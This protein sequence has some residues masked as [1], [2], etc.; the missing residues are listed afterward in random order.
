[1]FEVRIHCIDYC[2]AAPTEV[3]TAAS[4]APLHR[5]FRNKNKG[6][7]RDQERESD[8]ETN[9]D[10]TRNYG[11]RVPI[12]RVFGATPAGKTACAHIHGAFPYLFVPFDGYFQPADADKVMDQLRRGL[13]QALGRITVLAVTLARGV[14]FYGFHV[15]LRLFCKIYLLDPA[16]MSR[17]AEMLRLGRIGGLPA[18]QPHEAHVPF[19]LQFMTDYNLYGCDVLRASTA[20]ARRPRTGTDAVGGD[21]L[22]IDIAAHHI[23]NRDAAPERRIHENMPEPPT[24]PDERLVYSMASLWREMAGRYGRADRKTSA[25]MRQS[26]EANTQQAFA[27]LAASASDPRRTPSAWPQEAAYRRQLDDI[28]AAERRRSKAAASDTILEHP[29]GDWVPTT[30]QSVED[31]YPTPDRTENKKRKRRPSEELLCGKTD[32][33]TGGVGFSPSPD[34]EMKLRALLHEQESGGSGRVAVVDRSSGAP[35]RSVLP[36]RKK[37]ENKPAAEQTQRPLTQMF[38]VTKSSFPRD[39]SK[40]TPVVPST[41][42]K[43]NDVVI[44][45]TPDYDLPRLSTPSRREPTWSPEATHNPNQPFYSVGDGV[46]AFARRPPSADDVTATLHRHGSEELHQDAF[47][48][49]EKDI[50]QNKYDN[51]GAG[52]RLPVRLPAFAPSPGSKDTSASLLS[53]CNARCWELAALPPS[54]GAVETWLADED[55]QVAKRERTAAEETAAARQR[56]TTAQLPRSERKTLRPLPK[57]RSRGG[58]MRVLVLE[59]HANSR[60]TFLPNPERDPVQCVFWRVSET[61]RATDRDAESGVITVQRLLRYEKRVEV[62]TDERD[63]LKR[64]VELAR[65]LDPDILAGYETTASSWGYL[66]ERAALY[67]ETEDGLWQALGRIQQPRESAMFERG[68]QSHMV[69]GRHVLGIA[70]AVRTDADLRQ[71]TIASAAWKLLRLRVPTYGPR[72]L[73]GWATSGRA[74]DLTRL[75]RFGCHR[76]AVG[77]ALLQVTEFVARTSE[78]A[79]VLGVDFA[80][81]LGRG[82]QYKVESVMLRVAK[83]ECFVLPSPSREQVGHQKAAEVAPLVLEPRSGFYSSPVIVLDFA[84][85]YP[86]LMI[87]YNLCYSTFLGSLDPLYDERPRQKRDVKPHETDLNSSGSAENEPAEG[88]VTTTV[89]D[90]DNIKAS[91][92]IKMGFTTYER[93]DGLLESANRLGVVV[94]PTGMLYAGASTRQSLLARMLAELLRTRVMVRAAMGENGDGA[95]ASEKQRLH[96]RQLALKLLANVTYGYTSASFSGR[97]PCVEVADSIVQAGRQTLDRAMALIHADARWQ[98]AEVVYGDTD[99]LFVHLPGRTRAQAFSIGAAMAAAVTAVNPAPVRLKFEK[100]YHPCVLLAKKRYVGYRFDSPRQLAPIWDAK[101]IETVRRDGTPAASA[102][103]EASL[104]LLFDTADLSLVRRLVQQRCADVLGGRVSP[105]DLCFARQVRSPASYRAPPPGAVVVAR[106]T[107]RDPRAA[108]LPDGDRVPFVIVAGPPGT[109][110]QDRCVAPAELVRS[111]HL[112]LDAD[113]Y[114][115]H[116]LL[117]PL[118]RVLRLVGVDVAQ[119]YADMARPPRT[120]TSWWVGDDDEDG[121]VGSD[122]GPDGQQTLDIWLRQWRC[123]LE[124]PRPNIAPS[125]T[126]VVVVPVWAPRILCVAQSPEPKAR[127]QHDHVVVPSGAL[128]ILRR[129][130]GDTSVAAASTGLSDVFPL[131]ELPQMPNDLSLGDVSKDETSIVVDTEPIETDDEEPVGEG[132]FSVQFEAACEEARRSAVGDF[133]DS[134]SDGFFIVAEERGHVLGQGPFSG[135]GLSEGPST[136]QGSSPDQRPFA[137]EEP[138]PPGTPRSSEDIGASGNLFGEQYGGPMGVETDE[139]SNMPM[140]MAMAMPTSMPT[141]MPTAAENYEE[142]KESENGENDAVAVS[143]MEEDEDEDDGS[144]EYFSQFKPRPDEDDGAYIDSTSTGRYDLGRTDADE[145]SLF[146]ALTPPSTPIDM[147]SLLSAVNVLPLQTSPL[148]ALQEKVAAFFRQGPDF[149]SFAFIKLQESLAEHRYVLQGPFIKVELARHSSELFSTLHNLGGLD[150]G[151]LSGYDH[152]GNGTFGGAG[153]FGGYD[154]YGAYDG[155]SALA[156]LNTPRHRHSSLIRRFGPLGRPDLHKAKP[157]H[158]SSN[159]SLQGDLWRSDRMASSLVML[160]AASHSDTCVHGTLGKHSRLLG[161]AP[162]FRVTQNTRSASLRTAMFRAKLLAQ[163]A[164]RT[165]VMAVSLVD[166]RYVEM[167]CF[168]GDASW[169]DDRYLSFGHIVT[170]GVG[171]E[172]VIIWQAWGPRGYRLDDYIRAGHARLRSWEEAE[173]FAKDF[174][175]LASSSGIWNARRNHLYQQLFYIDINQMCKPSCLNRLITPHYEPWVRIHTLHNVLYEN[176]NKFRFV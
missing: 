112:R 101:G 156:S 155:L 93:P 16:A 53:A 107:A 28:I 116:S 15:G 103:M 30:R 110:L 35:K 24:N 98:P 129:H 136:S 92:S 142:D 171:P 134:D 62:A 152:S 135:E 151:V 128:A 18:L 147:I 157:V 131:Q 8:R 67:T 78:Q 22:Q 71:Y 49:D 79:R 137:D 138:S 80:S 91:T 52:R 60:G 123:E 10:S 176:M 13:D 66:A 1:M 97:M 87:A 170:I 85:L 94:A 146:C 21:L 100:V 104:R 95:D 81:V 105:A 5:A 86:S 47:F 17:A 70:T 68:D 106:H 121:G 115:R 120:T 33:K 29:L 132:P 119:W 58:G 12:I 44:P 7:G 143:N 175:E 54:V 117:P 64:V 126:G 160:S 77:A 174:D 173:T 118:D 19:V 108:L 41:D 27:Q 164:N 39:H 84:S 3:D 14:P 56:M 172:G 148:L 65:R 111:R 99:S 26:F 144:E 165:T 140:P 74:R 82:S 154:G 153:T 2:L 166:V 109:P 130:V 167:A 127:L 83:P 158:S 145:G 45:S 114:V 125:S 88:A 48:S 102:L 38:T 139:S 9:A 20:T 63:L 159:A 25:E 150:A 76:A 23:R 168:F 73:T 42:E 69:T 90:T 141:S 11:P 57:A 43:V 37:S 61:D 51:T 31:F 6:N 149:A 163:R 72:V 124:I 89:A 122:G 40:T 162:P 34:F 46:L 4:R 36:I 75:V 169:E 133:T 50:V 32:T 96:H 113:Y 161:S 59:L 55:A